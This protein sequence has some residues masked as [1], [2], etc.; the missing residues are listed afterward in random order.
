MCLSDADPLDLLRRVPEFRE[1]PLACSPA[2]EPLQELP[3]GLPRSRTPED[4]RR[5]LE[6]P[7]L[8]GRLA[9]PEDV[10]PELG[11]ALA[12]SA[13][14]APLS[15]ARERSGETL[16]VLTD[17][18]SWARPGETLEVL[19]DDEWSEARVCE[20]LP[21]AD[22]LCLLGGLRV[23]RSLRDVRSVAAPEAGMPR[24]REIALCRGESFE[25]LLTLFQEHAELQLAERC[26][27][28]W[29]DDVQKQLL[30]PIYWRSDVRTFWR[31]A[32]QE[33]KSQSLPETIAEL[34]KRRSLRYPDF[35]VWEI[36]A[37]AALRA[38]S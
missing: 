24:R 29:A 36:Q 19:T 11:P 35:P 26:A 38:G 4:T 27:S 2:T 37:G 34:E 22:L 10:P 16:E 7:C 13:G 33:L 9:A 5:D 21:P 17:W 30:G 1:H 31:C 20:L 8:S 18:P 25:A 15:C 23:R 14:L 6:P 3:P 32:V 28:F 12:G